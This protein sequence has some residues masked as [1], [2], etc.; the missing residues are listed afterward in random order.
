M[1]LYLGWG[2]TTL[3]LPQQ[4]FSDFR[5]SS[6]ILRK[7]NLLKLPN[8]TTKENGAKTLTRDYNKTTQ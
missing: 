8:R 6:Q 1:G 5:S 4:G 2:E 7:G 3:H